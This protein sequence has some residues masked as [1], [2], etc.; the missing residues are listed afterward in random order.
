MTTL[1]YLACKNVDTFRMVLSFLN[2]DELWQLSQTSSRRK[3]HFFLQL[4]SYVA[5]AACCRDHVFDPYSVYVVRH[6]WRFF[7]WLRTTQMKLHAVYLPKINCEEDGEESLQLLI[8]R[9]RYNFCATLS[10]TGSHLRRLTLGDPQLCDDSKVLEA[11]SRCCGGLEEL[12]LRCGVFGDSRRRDAAVAVLA[13]NLVALRRLDLYCVGGIWSETAS[14]TTWT[15]QHAPPL[16]LAHFLS[17]CPKLERINVYDGSSL[18]TAALFHHRSTAAATV[19]A[20]KRMFLH[21]RVPLLFSEC[22]FMKFALLV[23]RQWLP[24]LESLRLSFD[25]GGVVA[26]AAN[27]VEDMTRIVMYKRRL[28]YRIKQ[29]SLHFVTPKLRLW[30]GST[31]DVDYVI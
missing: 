8:E 16:L 2:I 21:E 29:N 15:P 3:N 23:N 18:I 26:A 7:E 5:N 28:F 24:H 25:N 19:P 30:L 20:V 10:H 13:E 4:D 1:N 17:R 14:T 11:L 6:I 12:V 27:H 22:Y 9:R 31:N